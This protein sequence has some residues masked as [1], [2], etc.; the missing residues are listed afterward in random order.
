MK[1]LIIILVLYLTTGCSDENQEA[2]KQVHVDY[3]SYSTAGFH[4]ETY[5]IHFNEIEENSLCPENATCVWLGRIV[6]NLTINDNNYVIG[7]GDLNSSEIKE[8]AE[9]NNVKV[10]I[11]DVIDYDSNESTTLILEFFLGED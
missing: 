5:S 2:S 3:K 11:V 8:L 9:V 10:K 6:A 4:G 1:Y 7:F